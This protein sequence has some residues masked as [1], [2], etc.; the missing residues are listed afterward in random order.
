[1]VQP[2]LGASRMGNIQDREN[3]K[4]TELSKKDN[5]KMESRKGGDSTLFTKLKIMKKF[6][7]NKKVHL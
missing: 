4:E 7:V 1:M 5:S 3:I 6:L 2:S